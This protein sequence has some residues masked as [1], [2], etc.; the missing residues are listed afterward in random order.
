MASVFLKLSSEGNFKGIGGLLRESKRAI[1]AWAKSQSQDRNVS[2]NN[3]AACINELE[4]K[5][6]TGALPPS[7]MYQVDTCLCEQPLSTK[8]PRIFALAIN[9]AVV[10]AEFGAH[11]HNNWSWEIHLRRRLFD[12]EVPSWNEL[13][14][15]LTSFHSSGLGRDWLQWIGSSDGLFSIKVMKAQLNVGTTS[16][17]NWKKVLWF[18]LAPP[19]VEAFIWLI[20]HERVPVKVELLKRGRVLASFDLDREL[21]GRFLGSASEPFKVFDRLALSLFQVNKGYNVAAD[22]VCY[23]MDDMVAKE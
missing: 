3:L 9:K 14:T 15:L 22:P 18:G 20:L 7:T 1:K 10:I 19:K 2:I 5:I 12:W 23:R 17:V 6:Q 4:V 11:R 21:L 13:L 16:E 8:F